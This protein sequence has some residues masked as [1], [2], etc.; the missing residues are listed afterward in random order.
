MLVWSLIMDLCCINI[1]RA[2]GD[3]AWW[4]EQVGER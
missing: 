4:D 2:M 1:I 3:A